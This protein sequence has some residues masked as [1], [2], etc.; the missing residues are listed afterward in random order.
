MT[1]KYIPQDIEAK[2]REKWEKQKTYKT[3]KTTDKAKKMYILDMFPYPSGEG[4]H[5]GHPRG[6]TATDILARFYRMSGFDILHPMGWDAFGLPAENAAIKAKKNPLNMVPA[7]IAKFKR[8]LK[9]LGFSYDWDRELA[10][11][12]PFYYKWTQWLFIQ[13]F[14]MGLLYK[15]NTPVYYCEFC[16]TGLAEEEVLANG[17]HERCGNKITRKTLPQWV[18]RITEYADKLLE[19]L[20]SLQWPEGIIQMQRN[21][22]GRREGI[23]I[24]YRVD[25]SDEKIVCFTT[26]P[27]TNFGATFVVLAPEHP[28]LQKIL[29]GK[30]SGTKETNVKKIKEYIQKA[31]AKTDLDRISEI[32][33]KTGIFT[34]FYAINRLNNEKMPIWI[35]DFVLMDYGTGAVVGVPAHDQRDFDFAQRFKIPVIQVIRPEKGEFKAAYEGSG[36]LINSGEW[37]GLDWP[38]DKE[39]IFSFLEKKGLGKRVISYHLRDW[40][41]SRQRYWGEP[42]PMIFCENCA[43]KQII[44]RE[45]E[46]KN[47]NE[48]IRK[49]LYGWFPIREKELPLELPHLESYEPAKNGKSPLSKASKWVETKCPNCGLSAVRETDTMPNWAGSC[50]YFLR[51]ADPHND[52]EAWSQPAVE[53]FL[54]VDWYIGGAEHAVLHLL[55]SRFWVK[56]LYDLRLLDFTEPFLRLRNQGMVLAADHR[57]MSKSLGNVINP[58]QVVK[59]YGADSLRIY[60]MF[61]APFSQEIAWSIQTLQ[62]SYR[63]LKRIWQIYNNSAKITKQRESQNK[64][65]VAKLQATISKVSSDIT[66]VK[67]NTAVAAMMEFLN[68]WDRETVSLPQ[69]DAKSF[70]KILAPF[71]PFITEEIWQRV[72]NE[73]ESIHFSSW[74]QVSKTKIS[75]EEIK[76]PIQTN[77]KLRGII[78]I[79]DGKIDQETVVKKALQL[80]AVKKILAGKKYK[81]IY[82]KGKILNFYFG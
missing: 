76:I 18:F 50:W 82:K 11:I 46:T 1:V 47:L 7:N 23:N 81:T 56:A 25:G 69:N 33:K 4:L 65:V 80:P 38:R 2:W 60:E 3:P 24:E 21:W 12:D 39:K 31:L 20:D 13:F 58:D 77:G 75:I 64:Q 45:V 48:K 5:V 35:S 52:K 63:F 62:G 57:K 14:K 53:K 16:K 79:E 30:I 43:K 40:I 37:N 28:F 68:E 55:Y 74:P 36:K 54:P 10:T 49:T 34:G 78:V 44:S 42:I 70:L 27:D 59:E 17:T 71:A 66:N 19:G 73:K 29:D 15:K 22:I 9:L 32:K 26:R 67:F 8:Q 6:Y 61:M 51:F 41:F 72:F